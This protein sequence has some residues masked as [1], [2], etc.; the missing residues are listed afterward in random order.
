AKI[1]DKDLEDAEIV[2]DFLQKKYL[3]WLESLSLLRSMS[4]GVR[5][6][7]KLEALAVSC[8]KFIYKL[9]TF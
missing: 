4:E 1:S 8:Y 5:E 6:V 3:Y 9:E 7:Q 2:H